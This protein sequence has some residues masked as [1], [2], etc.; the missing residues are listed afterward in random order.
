MFVDN[1]GEN[2]LKRAHIGQYLGIAHIITL[3]A[4]LSGEGIRSRGSLR[5]EVGIH[6]MD[7]PPPAPPAPLQDPDIFILLTGA[8]YVTVNSR[9]D[10][11]KAVKKHILKD[12]VPRGFDVRIEEIQ[13]KHRQAIEEKDATITLLNDDLKIVNM[14]MWHCKH[15]GIYLVRKVSRHHYPS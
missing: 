13:E 12:I 14:I 3:T 8:L 7:P 5:V 9:K 4:K 10:K 15:K 2:W 11:G 1:K 6:S